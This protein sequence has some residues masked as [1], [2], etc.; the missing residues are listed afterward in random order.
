MC[1]IHWDY[2]LGQHLAASQRGPWFKVT[3][4]LFTYWF[5]CCYC[6]VPQ[7]ETIKVTINSVYKSEYH[8]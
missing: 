8:L 7:K 1:L 3:S 4:T 5:F 2:N 6:F